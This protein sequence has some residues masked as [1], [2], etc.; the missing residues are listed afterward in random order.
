MVL[1]LKGL[2]LFSGEQTIKRREKGSREPVRRAFRK[3]SL[4]ITVALPSL[5]EVE[6]VISSR[7]A[8]NIWK[9][10]STRLTD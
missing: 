5:V 2:W 9:V 4:V 6:M 1:H 10:E 3:S 7:I 8:G